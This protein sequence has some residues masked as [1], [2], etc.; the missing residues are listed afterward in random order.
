MIIIASKNGIVGIKKAME[1]LKGGGSALDAIEVGIYP[2]EDNPEDHTVGY[3]GFH[4]ILGEVELDASIMNG[5]DLKAGCV[6]CVKG[7]RHPISIARKVMEM[8]PH[9]FLVGEGAERFAAEMGFEKA[10]LLSD[11]AY[12]AW[13]DSFKG[14]VPEDELSQ[15]DQRK[16]LAHLVRTLSNPRRTVG[17]VN[18]IAIDKIGDIGSGVSTSGWFG[19]YPG[20]LGDSPVIGAGNYADNRYGAAACTGMGE[21]SIRAGTTRSLVHYM[22]MGKSLQEAGIQAM[23]DLNDLGGP[24]SSEMNIIAVDRN[25]QPAAFSSNPQKT[26]IYMTDEMDEPVELPRTYVNVPERWEQ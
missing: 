4:S 25:G 26:Y 6:G 23:Q 1:V 11:W 16:D 22:K 5:R 3:S 9:V 19:K 17:T 13:K 18:F 20:R 21:M 14:L 2:V 24:Y 8:L 15:I 12:D 10:N 7:Y